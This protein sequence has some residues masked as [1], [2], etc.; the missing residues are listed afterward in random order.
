MH[1]AIPSQDQLP[2]AV[3]RRSR[4]P[5]DGRDCVSQHG[6]VDMSEDRVGDRRAGRR[7]QQVAASAGEGQARSVEL[8]AVAQALALAFACGPAAATRCGVDRRAP[9]RRLGRGA[10]R[11]W[12]MRPASPAA[13]R[14]TSSP[15][16]RRAASPHRQSARASERPEARQARRGRRRARGVPRRAATRQSGRRRSRGRGGW[17]RAGPDTAA[18]RYSRA[19]PPT[20]SNPRCRCRRCRSPPCTA[21]RCP[22]SRGRAG[23]VTWR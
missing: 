3:L 21:R 13:E 17:R 1:G 8:L 2:G 14:R 11:R 12:R 16:H 10:Q 18:R 15:D 22:R 4:Q 7:L 9:A 23:G 20:R 5:L 19:R 6:P